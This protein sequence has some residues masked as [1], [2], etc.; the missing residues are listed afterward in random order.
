MAASINLPEDIRH[1]RGHSGER[2][3]SPVEKLE[4]AA[5]RRHYVLHGFRQEEQLSEQAGGGCSQG[6][7]IHRVHLPARDNE[8]RERRERERRQGLGRVDSEVDPEIKS[9][10]QDPRQPGY[11]CWS[12]TTVTYRNTS[13]PEMEN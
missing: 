3:L 13:L 12:C 4:P 9:K 10:G 11:A 1:I 8:G 6:V 7:D 2:R 5:G